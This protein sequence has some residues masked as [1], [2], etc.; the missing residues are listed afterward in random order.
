MSFLKLFGANSSNNSI[1]E[2]LSM[3]SDRTEMR[4]TSIKK[5]Q[6]F[7]ERIE[8]LGDSFLDLLVVEH[9]YDKGGDYLDD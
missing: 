4:E 1:L 8:F 6:T 3:Q 5:H 2:N 9:L 7:Y